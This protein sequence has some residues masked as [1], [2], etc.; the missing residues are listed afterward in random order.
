MSG[1]KHNFTSPHKCLQKNLLQKPLHVALARTHS[2]RFGSFPDVT[3]QASGFSQAAPPLGGQNSP[4]ALPL[5][6]CA[7]SLL[8]TQEPQGNLL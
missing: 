4:R 2:S 8:H 7:A 3:S 1:K 5:A 6:S